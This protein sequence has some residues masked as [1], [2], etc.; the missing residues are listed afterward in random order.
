MIWGLN[1]LN[2]SV[3]CLKKTHNNHP[4]N[5][6]YHLIEKISTACNGFKKQRV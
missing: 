1:T 4:C 2:H 6:G 3:L 5:S